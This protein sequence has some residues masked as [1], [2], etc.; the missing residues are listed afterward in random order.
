MNT[1]Q[2]HWQTGKGWGLCG[3]SPFFIYL[4]WI[5]AWVFP[6]PHRLNLTYCLKS[7]LL[8]AFCFLLVCM[9]DQTQMFPS[10]ILPPGL[11]QEIICN[12]ERLKGGPWSPELLGGP[13][14][15]G[16]PY[17]KGG[18]LRSLF[19]PCIWCLIKYYLLSIFLTMK[20]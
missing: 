1:W 17:L 11:L 16:W 13:K 4:H 14:L 19:I 12:I 15:E 10:F 20:L 6:Q 9:V 5:L 2:F 3:L 7:S 8:L 18:D